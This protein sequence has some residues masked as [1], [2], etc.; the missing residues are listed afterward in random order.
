MNKELKVPFI[1]LA[2]FTGII[3]AWKT[4]LGFFSGA[5]VSFVA[6]LT[7][8]VMLILLVLQKTEVRKRI[9]DMVV[10]AGVITLLEFIAYIPFE[11]GASSYSVY[12]GFLV[13]Q[14]VIT[15]IS[16]LFFAYIAFR[17][18][19]EYLGK[20]IGFVEFILGNKKSAN[21]VQKEKVNKELEN[22]SLEEKPN[23]IIEELAEETVQEDEEFDEDLEEII[24]ETEVVESSEE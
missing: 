1:L 18:I 12:Q 20:R 11:F 16:I 14:N 10:I 22:G 8:L 3:M 2:V 7:I 15:F 21:K 17:F 4:L 9:I 5:G 19:T 23:K 6:I 24:E 13:Y